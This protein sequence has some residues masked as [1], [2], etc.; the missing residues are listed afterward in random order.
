MLISFNLWS[1]F[2]VYSIIIVAFYLCSRYFKFK[3]LTVIFGCLGLA[4]YI[5]WRIAYTILPFSSNSDFEIYWMWAYLIFECLSISDLFQNN[6]F[7]VLKEQRKRPAKDHVTLQKPQPK[8]DLLLPTFDEPVEIL[9]KTFLC[10]KEIEWG[11]LTINV[12]D[13]GR[14]FEVEKVARSL[15]LKYFTRLSNEGAKAGNMNNALQHLDGDFVAIL[16][17]DFMAYKHF[18]KSAMSS[19][20]H[21]SVACVQF[22]QTFFNPDPT[23]KKFWFV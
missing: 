8:V 7:E 22:P 19:F 6:A 16:D 15:G 2:I 3:R 12:L 11:N 14:R 5:Y 10:A 18:I 9:R 4:V 13:D 17:A 20:D 23:Q 1:L 21:E